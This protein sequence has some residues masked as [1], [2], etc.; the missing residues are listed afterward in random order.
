MEDLALSVAHIVRLR[1]RLFLACCLGNYTNTS[2][3]TLVVFTSISLRS[4]ESLLI[5]HVWREGVYLCIPFSNQEFIH[6]PGLVRIQ[7]YIGKKS[8][9]SIHLLDIKL[10]IYGF[11]GFDVLLHKL[12]GSF[13][14]GNDG[15]DVLPGSFCISISFPVLSALWTINADES[16]RPFLTLIEN[17]VCITIN[18]SDHF[19][20]SESVEGGYYKT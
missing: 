3:Q 14:H 7:P 8:S 4:K 1:R 17:L 12:F 18:D 5:L 19:H 6:H 9:V 15:I 2:P 10:K 13:S 11:A 16:N 20:R